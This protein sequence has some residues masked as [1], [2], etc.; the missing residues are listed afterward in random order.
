MGKLGN[1]KKSGKICLILLK[2]VWYSENRKCREGVSGQD[3]VACGN[4]NNCRVVAINFWDIC[5]WHKL[6]KSCRHFFTVCI[7]TMNF[8]LKGI[9][10][11]KN[12]CQCPV[13]A[14]CG[15]KK[16]CF[17]LGQILG[18]SKKKFKEKKEKFKMKKRKIKL[19][20]SVASLALVAAVA[21]IGVFAATQVGASF[22]SKVTFSAA[23]IAAK[24]TTTAAGDIL[25]TVTGGTDDNFMTGVTDTF[26][27]TLVNDGTGTSKSHDDI[28]IVLKAN[29]SGFVAANSTFTYTFVIENTG[30]NAISYNVAIDSQD[31]T[32]KFTADKATTSADLQGSIAVA[33]ASGASVTVIIE[34]T[35]VADI[36]TSTGV[37]GV[38]VPGVT[39]TLTKSA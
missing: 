37:G 30:E 23:G 22:N 27:A 26:D 4:T 8:S 2:G 13:V 39:I 35:C 6:Q 10:M 19:F 34:Y 38:A 25:D 33:G 16:L 21:S 32:T 31:K 12:F 5:N 24:I 3:E 7:N 18:F 1:F 28:E 15:S 14:C 9:L 29:D 11:R 17:G 36:A 20:A